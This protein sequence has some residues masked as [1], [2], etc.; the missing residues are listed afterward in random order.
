MNPHAVIMAMRKSWEEFW[1]GRQERPRP[2]AFIV[3]KKLARD[4]L[5]AR[6]ENEIKRKTG[7]GVDQ[8]VPRTGY[9]EGSVSV[10][11]QKEN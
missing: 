8:I 2:D 10:G 9:V 6:V 4:G 11:R 7:L 1:R 5:S 3:A